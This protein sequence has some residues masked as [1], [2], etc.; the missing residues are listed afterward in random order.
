MTH[1]SRS[2]PYRWTTTHGCTST[3]ERPP[4][5]TLK[6]ASSLPRREFPNAKTHDT[7]HIEEFFLLEEA[8]SSFEEANYSR[9]RRDE[10][11][12]Q[13]NHLRTRP[14]GQEFLY[15]ER[16][17]LRSNRCSFIGSGDLSCLSWLT[18]IRLIS[19]SDIMLSLLILIVN[20]GVFA[21]FNHSGGG[22]REFA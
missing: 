22:E 6:C 9:R 7:S 2:E 18:S 12:K 16:F 20:S 11:T 8:H 15:E 3:R 14:I 21:N 4:L 13:K 10:R 5:F 1:M 19:W 17:L